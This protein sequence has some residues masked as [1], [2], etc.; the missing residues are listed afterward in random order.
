MTAFPGTPKGYMQCTGQLLSIQ[1]NNALFS[2]LGTTYGGDGRT[3]FGLP[4]L[5]GKVPIGTG[6]GAGLHARTLAMTGG[7]TEVTLTANNLPPHTHTVQDNRLSLP[8]G[9]NNNTHNPVGTYAGAAAAGNLYSSTAGT[10]VSAKMPDTLKL[11]DG[12]PAT[13]VN[14]MQPYLGIQFFIAL[15]GIYPSRN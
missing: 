2:L 10:G 4:N 13:A 15:E 14:N 8:A 11:D 1:Q 12:S 5:R 7:V 3:T 9:D 6:Q